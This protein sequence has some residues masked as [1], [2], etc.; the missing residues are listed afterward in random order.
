[1][2]LNLA[3]MLSVRSC[4]NDAT[5]LQMCAQIWQQ[6]HQLKF[7]TV[8]I[9]NLC[10]HSVSPLTL[11]VRICTTFCDE[12]CQYLATGRRFPKCVHRYGSK[13]INWNFWQFL[14]ILTQVNK[15]RSCEPLGDFYHPSYYNYKCITF[16]VIYTI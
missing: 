3:D 14:M 15:S 1:M 2:Q 9:T 12:V 11:W 5:Q 4:T 8:N 6:R 16:Q 7:L 13:G 10:N